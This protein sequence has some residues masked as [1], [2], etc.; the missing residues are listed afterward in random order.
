MARSPRTLILRDEAVV[1]IQRPDGST[2][3]EAP[4]VASVP[5]RIDYSRRPQSPLV[6]R[7]DTLLAT[8]DAARC[9]V[10]QEFDSTGLPWEEA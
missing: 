10:D 8:V 3:L 6:D 2:L 7:I 5:V 1:R 9:D 4:I